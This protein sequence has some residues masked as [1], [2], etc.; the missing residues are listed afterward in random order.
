MWKVKV[1]IQ[2][3]LSHLPMG[4]K[5]NYLLQNL[6]NSHSPEKMANRINDLSKSLKKLGEHVELE[7]STVVE[8]GTGWEAIGT[9][10]LYLMG[11]K[12]CHTYDHVPH[13][14]FELVQMLINEIENHIDE[15][16]QFISVPKPILDERL[17]KI[18]TSENLNDFFEKANIIYHAPGDAAETGLES[19]SVDV[20]Y[21]NAVLE[22]VPK[23]VVNNIII[24][25]KRIL[26]NTGVAYHLI[27]LHDHYVSF[28]KKISKVNFLQY[29]EW[30]W[31]FFVYNKISYHNRLREKQFL[32]IFKSHG[33]KINWIESK[34]DEPDIDVLK[35]IKINKKFSGMTPEELAV[36]R[37]EI[38]ISF[39]SA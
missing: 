3:F 39:P 13:L 22:H 8:I 4:E 11:V 12:I 26:K 6:K 25:S 20:V 28:D 15:I 30:L 2:F 7:G 19:N 21:S 16:S 27:G 31:A 32:T 5:I 24:E 36:Y 1:L 9:I 23:E 35:K 34:I 38:I 33:A 37:T 18:K 29:P 14:R 17:S 10:L